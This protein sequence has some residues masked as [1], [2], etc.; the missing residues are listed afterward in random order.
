MGATVLAIDD[1]LVTLRLLARHISAAGH[2]VRTAT[3][4]V[5]AL[6]LFRSESPKLI[7]SDLEM[8]GMDGYELCQIIRSSETIGC[9]YI[10]ILSGHSDKE[11]ILKAF[12]V[13]ADDFLA[14]PFDH[15]ELI[16]RINAGMRIVRLEEQLASDR[17]AIHKGNAEL[18]VLN[19][20]LH[21]MAIT[22]ELT[23]L[24]NRREAIRLLEEQWNIIQGHRQPLSCFMLDI[25]HF[26]DINDTYGHEAGDTVLRETSLTL[27]R[28]SRAGETVCRVGGEEFLVLCPGLDITKAAHC[29]ERM[30]IAVKEKSFSMVIRVWS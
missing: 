8:S 30:R 29:A 13:G 4:S 12:E 14:K 1:D 9:V 19:E 6:H 5:E 24:V 16:A 26:K 28:A 21:A 11:R 22:D 10:I 18:M 27:Q 17:L 15:H 25:D 20:K 23:G 7:V 3:S 2:E